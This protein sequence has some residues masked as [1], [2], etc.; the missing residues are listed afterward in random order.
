MHMSFHLRVIMPTRRDGVV[1]T[2]LVQ[3]VCWGVLRLARFKRVDG[4]SRFSW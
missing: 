4:Q 2:D 3:V 1:M